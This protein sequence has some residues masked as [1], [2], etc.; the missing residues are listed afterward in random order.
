MTLRIGIAG[1]RRGAG[2]ARL[3]A[4]RAD[5]Q[6]TA[7][8][9]HNLERATVVA[10][11]VG[12]KALNSYDDLCATDVDAVVI[13]TPPPVHLQ[14]TIQALDAGKHVLCEVPAVYTLDEADRLLARVVDSGLQYMIAENVCY[15]PCVQEMHRIVAAGRIGDVTLLE[16]EYVH[17]CR[18][19]LYGRDDGLGGGTDNVPSWRAHLA[20]I[21]YCTH[22]LGP[23]LMMIDD[24][25]VSVSCVE[26]ATGAAGP[27][28][29]TRAQVATFCTAAGRVIREL[30]AFQIARE[31]AHHFLAAYGTSGAIETDRYDW[32]GNLKLHVEGE[33]GLVDVATSLLH[34]DAPPEARAGGHGTSEY[35]MVDDF[36]R[37]VRHDTAPYLDVRAA[38][39]MTVPG[40][41][42]AE[43]ARRGGERIDVPRY[44]RQE[45]S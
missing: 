19:L 3:F 37:A 27:Q 8:C 18:S 1:M 29:P 38:L 26:T 32:T 7:V 34:A 20:P 40:I 25:I 5:C 22:E 28:G 24:D 2:F 23:L 14:C 12:A 39:A 35:Y 6:V 11:E 44:H 15:F 43:S 10:A 9:D 13:V 31:P 36:V 42:A 45:Q 33:G 17:D 41:C 30:T 4:A 21:Q 16:G